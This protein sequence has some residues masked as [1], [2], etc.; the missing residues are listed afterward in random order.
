MADRPVRP[1]DRF[2]V[3]G[4]PMIEEAEINEVTDSLRK[5]WL[6]TG[7]KVAQF[8]DAFRAYK[9][10]PHAVALSSCTAALHLSMLAAD[11]KPGDEVITTAMTFCSSVNAIIHAGATPVLVDVDS[12]TMNVDPA[13]IE[14]KITPK[15]R[16]L[17]PVHFAGR[18]CDMDAICDIAAR[19]N[20]LLIEDCAH[21][22]EAEY[23]GQ[24][25]GL[26]GDFGCFSFYVTKNIITGEGGMV[27][28]RREE[29]ASNIK[30]LA[31]H[32]MS[33]DAW[34]R[35]KDE[36]FVH[37]YVVSA[38]YKYNMMDLQAAIGIHQLKRIDQYWKKRK[39]IWRRY[40]EAFADL[41]VDRPAEPE[42][43][44]RHAY[45]LYTILVDEKKTG[46]ERDAFL[47]AL[48]G[49]NI[50]AGVHY[51]SIP[52]HP[53]YRDTFGWKLD[54][55]PNAV[56]IGRRTVSLPLSAKLSNDD[57]ED[58]IEAVRLILQR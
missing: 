4:S 51:M 9:G 56:S 1:K 50:G 55:Y 18:P 52:E 39:A 47:D 31:L 3:F 42:P 54:D 21:A 7:P 10:A 48:H 32:G 53:F 24:K 44:T 36:G 33:K 58:V 11:L 5:G 57:V 14:M 49:H 41:P 15:T 22:I 28:T 26:F 2:L 46:M 16:A 8:E 13:R 23:K 37:Y 12:R 20:L 45:H 25:T 29:D 27:L 40:D 19:H 38:G 17:L 35:F 43:D 30:V 34:K 6:G